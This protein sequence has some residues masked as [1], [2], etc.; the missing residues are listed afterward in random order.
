MDQVLMKLI[1]TLEMV[2]ELSPSVFAVK[3]IFQELL[4]LV[5][6]NMSAQINTQSTVTLL[7]ILRSKKVEKRV[8]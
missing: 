1:T 7:P 4:V 8:R 6:I 5:N 3:K 2:S